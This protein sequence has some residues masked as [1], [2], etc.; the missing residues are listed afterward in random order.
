MLQ[1]GHRHLRAA[2][3]DQGGLQVVEALEGTATWGAA[4]DKALAAKP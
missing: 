2:L 1:Q 3:A 4:R